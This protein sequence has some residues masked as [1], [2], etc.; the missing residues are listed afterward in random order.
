MRRVIVS[1]SAILCSA[2][3][4]SAQSAGTPV[5]DFA[6]HGDI[7]TVLHPGSASYDPGQKS[8]TI[9]GSGENMLTTMSGKRS[10]V[11]TA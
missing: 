7:G 9:S 4:V 2:G 5:G 10:P 3:L 11:T 8:Y 1:L 6:D